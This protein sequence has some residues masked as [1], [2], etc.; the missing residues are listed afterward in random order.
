MDVDRVGDPSSWLLCIRS[1]TGG[2][3]LEVVAETV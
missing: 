3:L 2:S 1:A